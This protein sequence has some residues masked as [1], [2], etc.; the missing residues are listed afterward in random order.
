M[1]LPPGPKYLIQRA[2]YIAAPPAFVYA[3]TRVISAF[4]SVQTPLWLLILA[5]VLAYPIVLVINVQYTCYV[6]EREAR[7]YGA[8]LPPRIPDNSIGSTNMLAVQLSEFRKGYVG[9]F[10]RKETEQLGYTINIRVLFENRA[11]FNPSRVAASR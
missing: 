10:I 6:D 5:S 7:K 2:H 11:C 4:Y 1:T 8:V 3:L 9:D